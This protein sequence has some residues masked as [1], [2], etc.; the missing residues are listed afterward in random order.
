M[1]SSDLGFLHRK[2]LFLSFFGWQSSQFL[3]SC[4]QLVTVIFSNY[5]QRNYLEERILT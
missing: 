4:K 1:C 3:F 5:I 2:A